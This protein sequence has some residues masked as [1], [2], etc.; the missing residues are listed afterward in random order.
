[1]ASS[2]TTP[3]LE[4]AVALESQAP[5]SEL[6]IDIWIRQGGLALQ[7]MRFRKQAAEYAAA[8]TE[9]EQAI[10]LARQG[11][12]QRLQEL[13]AAPT[14]VAT[15]KDT[16]EPANTVL[17]NNTPMDS[18]NP[19]THDSRLAYCS[20]S[21]LPSSE[22]SVHPHLSH[23]STTECGNAPVLAEV[24]KP[25]M[26]LVASTPIHGSTA[27]LDIKSAKKAEPSNTVTPPSLTHSADSSPKEDPS[28]DSS[29]A[30]LCRVSSTPNVRPSARP[31]LDSPHRTRPSTG[32]SSHTKPRS[33]D[34]NASAQPQKKSQTKHV[35]SKPTSISRMRQLPSWTLSLTM[36]LVL[37]ISLA[38]ITVRSVD[39]PKVLA[40]QA[41][42]VASEDVSMVIPVDMPEL[43]A[44]DEPSIEP[45]PSS[46]FSSSDSLSQSLSS[47]I[48]QDIS[49][50]LA[51]SPANPSG[52]GPIM[53]NFDASAGSL[54]KFAK[55]EFFGVQAA[56]NTFCYIVDSS[57]SMRRDGAFD[58]AKGELIR[59]I[60]SMKPNQRYYI[61][62]FNEQI[63]AL[64]LRGQQP[65]SFPVHATPENIQ[66]TIEWMQTVRIRG[67]KSPNDVLDLALNM[68]PD[69]IFLLFDGDTRV[70]VA[71]HLEKTNRI[72][73]ILSGRVPRIP[74]HTVGFY[75]QEHEALLKRIAEQNMGTYRFIPAPKSLRK[76]SASMR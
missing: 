5:L 36:H 8:A 60:S 71:K 3:I 19:W 25:S 18:H 32:P 53:E 54:T 23:P 41:A 24:T 2:K 44:M 37:L 65:E 75:T 38:V 4:E 68:S 62:F 43:D 56:G 55:A 42:P 22:S 20:Q 73:D 74:I 48:A 28:D 39:A 40:I 33:N 9:L 50:G 66:A 16:K 61:Y 72:D 30:L 1:M 31:K 14:P 12:Y 21:T 69:G 35:P 29:Q 47:A 45:N 11:N 13:L 46:S 51:A 17:L 57:G 49:Q 6:Q 26:P 10:H 15:P 27:A 59:S 7:A 52:T 63:D 76:P 64:T 67:G 70:D 58:A 34:A